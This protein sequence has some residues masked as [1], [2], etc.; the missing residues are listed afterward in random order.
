MNKT[1]TSTEVRIDSTVYPLVA[2][3]KAAAALSARCVVEIGKDDETKLVLRIRPRLDGPPMAD[4]VAHFLALL[5][6]FCLLDKV[7]EE[8]K[9]IR[10]ALVR[11]AF[12]EALRPTK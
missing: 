12:H 1:T 11:A 3:Q 2:V 4:P 9:D 7:A 8:T 10:T 6:D 5:S